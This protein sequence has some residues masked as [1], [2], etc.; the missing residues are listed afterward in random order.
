VIVVALFLAITLAVQNLN[1]RELEARME[2]SESELR[3][4]GAQIAD[5]KDHQFGAM[6]QYIEAYARVE[7]LL[8]TYDQKLQKLSDLYNVAQERN[9]KP[10]LI[11]M[12]RWLGRYHPNAWLDAWEIMGLVHQ[13]NEVTKKEASVIHD[14]AALPVQEQLQFRHEEFT[15]LA[16]EEHAL[17]EKLLLVGQ[18]VSPERRTQ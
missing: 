11:P 8:S 15:P 4:V 16:A 5:I 7:P 18:R 2:Q 17:R 12:Q 10:R 14:M 3:V 9:R 6:S 1:Y 13:I